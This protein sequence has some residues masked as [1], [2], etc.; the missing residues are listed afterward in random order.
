MGQ[1]PNVP[2]LAHPHRLRMVQMLPKE[3]LRSAS[4]RRRKLPTPMVSEHLRLMHAAGCSPAKRR[5]EGCYR[6]VEPQLKSILKCMRIALEPPLQPGNSFFH[7]Y[8]KI[9]NIELYSYQSTIRTSHERH[10]HFPQRLH[11]ITQAGQ[12]SS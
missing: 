6:V 7:T 2:M 11:D 10:H 12:T 8:R 5:G 1:R 4:W 9:P 3:T